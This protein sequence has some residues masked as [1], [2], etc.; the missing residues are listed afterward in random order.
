MSGAM[1]VVLFRQKD[2]DGYSLLGWCN[3]MH[4]GINCLAYTYMHVELILEG[5]KTYCKCG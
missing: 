2:C 5:V 1:D 4:R 3:T